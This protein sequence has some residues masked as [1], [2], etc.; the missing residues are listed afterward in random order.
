MNNSYT[1]YT[2][3]FEGLINVNLAMVIKNFRLLTRVYLTLSPEALFV[4]V[5]VRSLIKNM[6]VLKLK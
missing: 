3:C 2:V 4:N 1:G 5:S 6:H